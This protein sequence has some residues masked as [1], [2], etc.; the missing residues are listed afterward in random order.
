[1]SLTPAHLCIVMEYTH[2]YI[3]T[4]SYMYIHILFTSV[5]Q[6]FL[7][8]QHLCIAM[9]YAPGGDMFDYVQRHNG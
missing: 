7:T 5:Q 8:P 3:H 4:C 9:E 6:V 2:I 1:M